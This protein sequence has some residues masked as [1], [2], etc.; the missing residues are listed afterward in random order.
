VNVWLQ[1][2]HDAPGPFGTLIAI[3]VMMVLVLARLVAGQIRQR[4][5]RSRPRHTDSG[6][7]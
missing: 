4:L 7:G 1:F 3:G 2:A 5:G 6:E